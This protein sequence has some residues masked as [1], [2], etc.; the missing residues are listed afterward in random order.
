MLYIKQF[1]PILYKCEY[2][3]Y[4]CNVIYYY[5]FIIAT[6]QRNSFFFLN[7]VLISK[8]SI[9]VIDILFLNLYISLMKCKLRIVLWCILKKQS[10]S[11]CSYNPIFLDDNLLCLSAK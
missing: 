4:K 3:T 1:N 6:L 7:D 2:F 11:C 5:L 9:R 10:G 8:P